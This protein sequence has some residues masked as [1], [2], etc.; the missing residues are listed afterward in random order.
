[1]SKTK[2]KL[3]IR[4]FS[5]Y[6]TINSSYIFLTRYARVIEQNIQVPNTNTYQVPPAFTKNKIIQLIYVA[7]TQLL[8]DN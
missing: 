2:I 3:T 5:I 4:T 8:S 1:M 7:Q 6:S